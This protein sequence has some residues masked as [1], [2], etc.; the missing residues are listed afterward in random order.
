MDSDQVILQFSAEICDVF[1]LF[2]MRK[3]PV[4]QKEL[5]FPA[6]DGTAYARQIVQL[7]E[8]AGEGCF[9]ALVRTRYNKY[10][11]LVFQV[12]IIADEGRLFAN[13]FIGKG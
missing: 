9:A 6:W 7:P 11:F 10:A 2:K 3:K 8:R 4:E 5:R 13:E 12:E 1:F